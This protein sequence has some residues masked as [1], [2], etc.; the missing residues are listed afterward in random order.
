MKNEKSKIK[1]QKYPKNQGFF[2]RV[3]LKGFSQAFPS[4]PPS[5]V[6]RAI[7][8]GSLPNDLLPR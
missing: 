5:L 6:Y 7:L 4:L 8:P 2:S 3:F 1:N